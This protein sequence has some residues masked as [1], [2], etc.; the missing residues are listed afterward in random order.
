[1]TVGELRQIT[2]GLLDDTE[3]YFKRYSAESYLYLTSVDISH[4]IDEGVI[5][6]SVEFLFEDEE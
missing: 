5:D 1:M 6:K 3:L 4:Q 2:E